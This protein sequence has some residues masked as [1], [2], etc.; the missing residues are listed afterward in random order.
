METIDPPIVARAYPEG[1]G[2]T[3]TKLAYF[4]SRKIMILLQNIMS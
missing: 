1:G 2:A 3:M 4:Q